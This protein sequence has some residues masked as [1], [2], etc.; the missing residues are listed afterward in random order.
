MGVLECVDS[1]TGERI[2]RDRL[3]DS[4]SVIASPWVAA[5]HLFVLDEIGQTF[6]VRIA[7]EFEVASVNTIEGLHWSSPSV[8]GDSLLIRSA[9]R[10][11]CVR[12]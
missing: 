6:A 1:A 2:W 10:L 8:A 12:E 5:G 7:D 11:T 3:P 4:A 9:E